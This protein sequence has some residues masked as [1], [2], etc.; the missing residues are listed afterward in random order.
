LSAAADQAIAEGRNALAHL[1]T[2]SVDIPDDTALFQMVAALQG[3]FGQEN[4]RQDISILGREG[5]LISLDT[6]VVQRRRQPPIVYSRCNC[7][8]RFNVLS[9][10]A[11]AAAASWPE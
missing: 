10:T 11:A 5:I 2:L 6:P 1:V 8:R 4:G 7:S 9:P 3:W